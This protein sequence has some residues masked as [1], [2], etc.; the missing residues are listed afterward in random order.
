VNQDCQDVAALLAAWVDGEL[1]ERQRDRVGGHLAVCPPC[2]ADAA[3][4]REI[5]GLLRERAPE[6]REAAP[7]ALKGRLGHA[8]GRRPARPV[9]RA[10]PRWFVPLAA[11]LVLVLTG[12]LAV[13]LLAPAGTVLA[14]EL[15]VDHM[16]CRLMPPQAVGNAAELERRWRDQRGWPITVPEPDARAG[17]EVAGLRRCLFHG[18]SLAHVFYDHHGETVSLF[19]LP[20]RRQTSPGLAIMGVRAATWSSGDRTYGLV[21]GST[22]REFADLVAVFRRHARE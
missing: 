22:E 16:K 18:G 12:G 17:L 11:G 21:G 2:A 5:R 4:Q 13:A 14:A 9:P 8:A 10:T 3:E 19:V 7:D 20:G 1:D 15:A 6:L